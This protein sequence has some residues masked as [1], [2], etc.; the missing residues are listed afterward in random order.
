M[1][2]NLINGTIKTVPKKWS[3]SEIELLNEYKNKNYS[4]ENISEKLNRSKTSVSIKY[5]RLNKNNNLY[6]K[7][8][9]KEKYLINEM[10]IKKIKPKSIL[11]VY[12]GE[13]FYKNNVTTKNLYVVDNDI[14][15]N[16]DY[17]LKSVDFLH[18]L[19]LK[20]FDLVDLDPFG[21]AFECFDYALQIAQKGL[22]ITFGEY[23]HLRWNRIDFV[24]HRYN[25]KNKTDFIPDSFIKYVEKRGLIFNKKLNV[26]FIGNFK[27]IIR[28][29]FSINNILKTKSGKKYFKN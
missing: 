16:C 11:D 19:K 8:H 25:I 21:S 1:N 12:A 13:S 22:I 7:K 24:E 4:F 28:V 23:G 20:K 3:K 27:N 15:G 5:K 29:Y 18:K 10:F 2:K 9:K 26:E 6:N 17:N 14:K